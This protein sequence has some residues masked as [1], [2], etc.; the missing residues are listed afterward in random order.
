MSAYHYST[1][2]LTA[3]YLCTAPQKKRQWTKEDDMA[4]KIQTAFRGYRC[5][6]SLLELKKKKEEYDVLMKKL[7]KDV[8]CAWTHSVRVV[9]VRKLLNCFVNN[10]V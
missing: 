5:R 9:T 2:I 10:W 3:L 4:R 7:E 8:R 6:K 1:F